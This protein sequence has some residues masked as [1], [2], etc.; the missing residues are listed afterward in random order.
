MCHLSIVKPTVI[1]KTVLRLPRQ[2]LE[3][4]CV[5]HL[6]NITLFTGT[7]NLPT[8]LRL[9][10]LIEPLVTFQMVELILALFVFRFP[11]HGLQE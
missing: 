4:N 11:L 6:I 8:C 9:C 2:R 3:S 5:C 7:E 10:S 1:N